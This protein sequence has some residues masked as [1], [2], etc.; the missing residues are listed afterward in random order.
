M[1]SE[2]LYQVASK[3]TLAD[4]KSVMHTLNEMVKECFKY[5]DEH[6]SSDLEEVIT[7]FKFVDN[8]WQMVTK[9]LIKEGKGFA[10]TDGF[11]QLVASKKEFDF[12]AARHGW[13]L[14]TP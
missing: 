9:R 4:D 10:R 14:K 8:V 6:R 11:Q 13:T 5:L 7:N 3:A 2:D 1:F 12:V